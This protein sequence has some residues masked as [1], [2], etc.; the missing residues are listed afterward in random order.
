MTFEFRLPDIGEGVVEGE[1]VRWLI[2]E[3]DDVEEDQPMVEVMTD[4]ATVEIPSPVQGRVVGRLGSEGDTVAVGSTLVVLEVSAA[5]RESEGT[6]S[7]EEPPSETPARRQVPPPSEAVLA[8]PAV[9]KLA[10][11][12]GVDLGEVKGTGPGGRITREDVE[13]RRD[14]PRDVPE[15]VPQAPPEKLER[16]T[17]PY[18]GLRRKIGAHMTE[19]KRTAVHYTFVEEVDATGLVQLRRTA[20]TALPEGQQITYLPFIIKAVVEGLKRYP[21]LNSTL[22]E[23]QEQIVVK[24]YYNIGIATATEEGLIVPVL[25]AADRR[26][27]VQLSREIFRLSEAARRGTIA[28]EDLKEGTFTIT[29]LGALGGLLATPVINYP[30]VAILGVHKISQRP[31]VVDGKIVVRHM[32]NLSLSLDHRVVDGA[33]G[34]QFMSHII[35][36]IE[37]PALLLFSQ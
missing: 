5:S 24:K 12:L 25:K 9:R 33:V 32:M 1:I 6:E 36:F 35:P 37:N 22:D 2:S 19:A 28:L 21:L 27:L 14:T 29:S 18:R 30:E 11:E 3:G 7:A 23:E 31:A 17:L 26:T 15:P 4:K 8:T 16:E 13:A 10:R 20:S 34:A